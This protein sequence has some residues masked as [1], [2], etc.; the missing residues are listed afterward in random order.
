[1]QFMAV[2][3]HHEIVFVDSQSYAVSNEYGGRIILIAWQYNSHSLQRNSLNEAVDTDV[4]FYD[5]KNKTLQQRLV[6]E[7][8]LAMKQLDARYR[9]RLPKAGKVNIVQTG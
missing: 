3:D 9:D 7:F 1:M 4:V 8:H 2:L 6:S 5:Q